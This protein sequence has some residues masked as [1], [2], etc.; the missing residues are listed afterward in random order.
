MQI[1]GHAR[2]SVT[3]EIYTHE[4][5]EAQR[6]A[7]GRIRAIVKTC[8]WAGVRLSVGAVG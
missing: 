4:N 2:I 1:L 5:R 8:G 7:L 3:L 6:E